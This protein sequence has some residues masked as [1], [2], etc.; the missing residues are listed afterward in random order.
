MQVD[1]VIQ[2][3]FKA[4]QSFKWKDCEA[5]SR[6]E[7]YYAEDNHYVVHDK[8]TKAFWFIVAKSPVKAFES[9]MSKIG[10]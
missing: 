10:K 5:D 6:Y 1:A 9:V 8:V 4:F 2:T 7:W 3:L